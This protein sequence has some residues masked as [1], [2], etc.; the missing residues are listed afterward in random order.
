MRIVGALWCSH[1]VEASD[2][3]EADEDDR[4]YR[5]RLQALLAVR[6]QHLLALEVA[7][8]TCLRQQ[9]FRLRLADCQWSG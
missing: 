2:P 8:C 1:E 4:D 9:R 6:D 3:H 5:G 7:A